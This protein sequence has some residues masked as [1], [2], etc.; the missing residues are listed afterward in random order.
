VIEKHGK[1]VHA[2]YVKAIAEQ[3]DYAAALKVARAAAA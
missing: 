3:P 2:Q 1:T